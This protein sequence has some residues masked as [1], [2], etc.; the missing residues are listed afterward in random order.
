MIGSMPPERHEIRLVLDIDLDA[1][2]ITGSIRP[3]D[4]AA[5]RFSGWISLAAALQTIRADL[6]QPAAGERS[7]PGVKR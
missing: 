3:A 5:R 7:E 4:G 1:D 6:T 2:P